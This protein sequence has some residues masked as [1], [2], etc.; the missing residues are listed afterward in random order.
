LEPELEAGFGSVDDIWTYGV[1][2]I[3]I[4]TL[5]SWVRNIA[6]FR[7]AFFFANILLLLSI[8]TVVAFS[9][10]KMW[11]QGGLALGV[12]WV[13]TRTLWSMVGYSIYTF[14]GVGILMPCMQ[15]CECP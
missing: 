4:L 8:I 5:L 10:A 15:A 11:E 6:K 3:I 1:I 7:F 14:E 12:K 9:F 13:N 2:I